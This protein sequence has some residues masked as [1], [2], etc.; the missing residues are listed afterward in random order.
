M[1]A[2]SALNVRYVYQ[3]PSSVEA[4]PD[5]RRLR[6]ATSGGTAEN[7]Y[8]FTG[9]MNYPRRTGDM[10]LTCSLVSRTR[11][12][13]PRELS[14][15]LLQAADPVVTSGGDRL[16]FEAFSVCCGVYCRVDLNPNAIDGD[17]VGR[18][19][20]N[21]DFNPP[22]RAALAGLLDSEQ[23]GLNVGADG[24]ELERAAGKVT[25]KKVKLPVRWLKGFVEV[26]AYQERMRPAFEIA[27]AELRQLLR[28]VPTQQTWQKV[29]RTFIVPAGKG[30]RM[31]QREAPGAV[32]LG[33]SGRLKIIEELLRHTKTVRI[34]GGPD[35]VSGWELVSPE[36]SFFLV[37]SPDSSRG[38]SGEGQVLTQIAQ[39]A[40]DTDHLSRVR[41]QLKWQAKIDPHELA[42]AI[43]SDGGTV[44]KSLSILGTR[45]LVGYDLAEGK[46]FHRELPFDLDMVENLHPR[47]QK[48]RRLVE[49]A[50]VRVVLNTSEKLDAFVRGDGAE[51]HVVITNDEARCTCAWHAGH[52]GERGPC[53]H[54]LAVELVD[55][56]K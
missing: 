33:A 46:Y 3:F 6:L 26:Q 24:V 1:A 56:E 53:S 41:A 42:K 31:S 17:W 28:T 14:E 5:S 7:P 40:T 21:V 50:A 2:A 10:L 19:T 44:T 43:G 20:T 32:A 23:V 36:A 30:I 22:M 49:E 12:Y 55:G 16:R 51:H 52:Q 39:S 27:A 37:M 47:M 18:G 34:Y 11:F 9:R 29:G 15:R 25:E 45:G 54:I 48:A 13:D 35:G 38:F 4:D 8:F